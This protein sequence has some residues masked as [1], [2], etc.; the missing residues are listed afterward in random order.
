MRVYLSFDDTDIAGAPIGTGRLARMFL[1]LLPEGFA[2]WGVLRHQQLVAEGIPYTSQN[3]SACIVLDTPGSAR[4]DLKSLLDVAVAHV[5]RHA[6]MGSDPGV[7]LATETDDLAALTAFGQACTQERKTQAQAMEAAKGLTLLGLGGT[8]D[9]II[10]AAAAIGLTAFGWCGRFIEYGGLRDFADTVR[11][12]DLEAAGVRVLSMDRNATVPAPT[13]LV[14]T[15]G[16][17]RPQLWAQA[18]VLPVCGTGPGNWAT[19]HAK[20]KKKLAKAS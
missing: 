12:T 6:S 3:S 2:P 16:W 19:L 5:E 11:V 8:N 9:G 1:P 10:G 18:P 4:D 17:L 14:H 13:D 7:C 20:S 15:A